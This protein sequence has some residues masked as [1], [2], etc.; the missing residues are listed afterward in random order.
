MSSVTSILVNRLVFNLRERAVKKLPVTV[1]TTG[2]FQTAFPVLQQPLPMTSVPHSSVR[3][4][5]SIGEMVSVG[6]TTEPHL[7][8]DDATR[9]FPPLIGSAAGS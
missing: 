6:E 8:A 2:I 4:N 3:Q 7:S 1:E 5:G 9:Y